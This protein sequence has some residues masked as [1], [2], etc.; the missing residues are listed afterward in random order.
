MASSGYGSG[1]LG[2]AWRPAACI[3]PYHQHGIMLSRYRHIWHRA[4]VSNK[5]YGMAATARAINALVNI[6]R[7][8]HCSVHVAAAYVAL[9][10]AHTVA[11][12]QRAL[13]RNA[14]C[15]NMC[16]P[17]ISA[18]S[19]NRLSVSAAL[20]RRRRKRR[21]Q[22]SGINHHRG[23]RVCE[24]TA[25]VARHVAS[26]PVRDAASMACHQ[27]GVM[28]ARGWRG[29]GG[30]HQSWRRHASARRGCRRGFK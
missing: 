7:Q 29:G 8:S 18:V 15:R 25:Y 2:M 30:A 16:A 6:R 9:C 3:S 20:R 17:R 1:W 11:S 28:A 4:R 14:P 24:I 26:K 23:A 19:A 13:M 5:C 21:H 10:A 22:S 12:A 27:S